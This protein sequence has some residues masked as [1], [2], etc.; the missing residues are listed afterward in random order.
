MLACDDRHEALRQR[1]E[2]WSKRLHVP[3]P[4]VRVRDMTRKWGSCSTSGDD[5][6]G[7]RHKVGRCEIYLTNISC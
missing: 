2:H 7:H 5:I 4:R 1:V 6:A 3:T